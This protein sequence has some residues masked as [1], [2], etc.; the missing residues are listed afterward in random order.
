MNELVKYNEACKA[1]RAAKSIDEVKNIRN[2]T[3]AIRAYAKQ[4]KNKSLEIDAAE[5]RLRAERRLGEFL[6]RKDKAT[7]GQPYQ[8]TGSISEPVDLVPTLKEMGI[9]KKLSSRSQKLAAVKEIE[10]EGHI[11]EWRENVSAENERVTLNLLKI[12]GKNVHV[13]NNSGNNEW[14]TPKKYIDSARKVM[15]SIDLDPASSEIANKAVCAEKYFTES[16]NGLDHDWSGN[17]WLNPP[18][19]QPEIK[20]FTNKLIRSDYDNA[21]CLTNNA[22][23]T[24]YGQLLL[25]E[26]QAVCF[27]NGRIKYIDKNGEASRAPLQGQMVTYFGGKINEFINEF[28]IHGICLKEE[29]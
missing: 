8:S 11:Q 19:S 17:I 25:F 5:I 18:Y 4:A 21:I 22:T 29:K 2:K 1:I 6:M 10:F 24:A 7:G 3:E 20:L 28:K 27:I 12:G 16:D 13:S 26:C 9:D 14:Y 15:G 23:E